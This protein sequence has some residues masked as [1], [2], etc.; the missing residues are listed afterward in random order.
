MITIAEAISDLL[1]VRDVVVVPGLG[2]FVK[3]LV[4]AE[5]NPVAN[6]FAIPSSQIE[7]DANLREDNDLVA[8]YMSEKDN[9]PEEE[10]KRLLTMF[11]TDCFNRLKEGKNVVLSGIGT[12]SY[13]RTNDLIF[14]PC[15]DQ[16]FNA[17]AFG[18]CDFSPTPV[19]LPKSKEEI[20]TEIKQQQKDKNTPVTV[21]EKAVHEDD[22][23]PNPHFGW[24]WIL[25]GILLM[26]AIVYG[27]YYFQIID[28]D[29]RRWKDHPPKNVLDT[30]KKTEPEMPVVPL[31]SVQAEISDSLETEIPVDTMM[32]PVADSVELQSE[33]VPKVPEMVEAAP[34]VAPE[35]TI[36]IIA[37]CFSMEENAERLANSLRD[38]GY[39]YA[40]IERRGS[41]WYVAYGR[42]ATE[43]E[44][45]AALREIRVNTDDKAW[46]MK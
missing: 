16:N 5:V 34:E 22:T 41:K 46:I 23:Q 6:Y 35:S 7:F 11:V 10:A 8:N 36:R 3:K 27:M 18:L 40:F 29:L 1:F 4:P 45:N 37:G 32:P 38:K 20:E 28:F 39:K 14:E 30:V 17:D 33:Q 24:L 13:D 44:A 42:Y 9:I 21:D 2:A 43:E 25:L 12:L 26:G 15:S 31:D 19:I